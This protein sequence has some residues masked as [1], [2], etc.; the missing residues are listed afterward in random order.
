MKNLRPLFVLP[1]LAV[2]IAS[3]GDN[4]RAKNFNDKTLVDGQALGFIKIANEAGLTEVK[5]STIAGTLSKNPRVISFAKMMVTDHTQAGKELTELADDKLVDKSDALSPEHQKT[6]DSMAKLTGAG[7]DRAYMGMMVNDH[8]QAVKLF[9]ET[10]SNKN[11]AVQKFA[12]KTLPTLKMHLDSAKAIAT[13][14]K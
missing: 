8:V 1:V 4:Q 6:I 14:L 13:S 9:E 5:A 12:R 2:V 7:F 11:N 10:S 3:C